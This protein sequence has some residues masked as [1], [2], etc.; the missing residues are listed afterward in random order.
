MEYRNAL[1]DRITRRIVPIAL[2]TALAV[3]YAIVLAHLA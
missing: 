3:A 1:P 2:T